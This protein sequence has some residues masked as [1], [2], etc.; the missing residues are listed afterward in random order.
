MAQ[1]LER[2][3]ALTLQA[4]ACRIDACKTATCS[5]ADCL[6]TWKVMMHSSKEAGT[7]LPPDM[8]IN[9]DLHQSAGT[10]R[11]KAQDPQELKCD[12]GEGPS[13]VRHRA[14]GAGGK[15][16]RLAF[17]RVPRRSELWRCSGSRGVCGWCPL[18]RCLGHDCLRLAA[19]GQRL[20]VIGKLAAGLQVLCQSSCQHL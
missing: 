19:A 3:R 8:P 20:P 12:Y 10:T 2:C 1:T 7:S 15:Q 18:W 11:C 13:A 6:G 14:Q 17:T 9:G 4:Q 16:Q 5:S